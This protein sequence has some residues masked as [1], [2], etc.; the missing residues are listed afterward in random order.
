MSSEGL[1]GLLSCILSGVHLDVCNMD[2][3][4]PCTS[5]LEIVPVDLCFV[6]FCAQ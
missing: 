2:I 3:F 1:S 5:E 6:C 4:I